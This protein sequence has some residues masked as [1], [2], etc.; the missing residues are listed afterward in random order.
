MATLTS[1]GVAAFL[2]AEY[3]PA[4]H[5]LGIL[6]AAQTPPPNA[7]VERN[8]AQIATALQSGVWWRTLQAAAT[9]IETRGLSPGRRLCLLQPR[10]GEVE[11]RAA[12]VVHFLVRYG[13]EYSV[14]LTDIDDPEIVAAS[15]AVGCAHL[16][17]TGV[18]FIMGVDQ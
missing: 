11:V 17:I 16:F 5:R 7:N 18:D 1:R 9:A 6:V 13:H 8:G 15:T 3:R 10:P 2:N 4:G 12:D 14:I